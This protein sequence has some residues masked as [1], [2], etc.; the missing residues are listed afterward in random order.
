[1]ISLN[2]MN[3]RRWYLPQKKWQQANTADCRPDS[4]PTGYYRSKKNAQTTGLDAYHNE[5]FAAS[6]KQRNKKI[7]AWRTVDAYALFAD[8]PFYAQLLVRLVSPNLPD[9]EENE[10]THHIQSE[11][12]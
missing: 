1:M 2:P 9:A 7:N 6:S 8:Q 11:H 3:S 5:Y 12:G 10:K 4:T